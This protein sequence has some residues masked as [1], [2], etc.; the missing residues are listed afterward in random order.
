MNIKLNILIQ[1]FVILDELILPQKIQNW[2]LISF[3]ASSEEKV[4]ELIAYEEVEAC[5]AYYLYPP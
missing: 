3:F 1:P 2:A 4:I 5:Y